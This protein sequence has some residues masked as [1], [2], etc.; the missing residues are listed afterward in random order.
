[1]THAILMQWIEFLEKHPEDILFSKEEEYMV[2]T[3]APKNFILKV[4]PHNCMI[5]T[6]GVFIILPV[7][8]EQLAEVNRRMTLLLTQQMVRALRAEI[9]FQPPESKKVF[10]FQFSLNRLLRG[11]QYL[12][13]V[14]LLAGIGW[15]LSG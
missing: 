12:L 3:Y 8:H 5:S 10:E 11:I 13:I 6:C 14:L 15:L 7:F 4:G 1:M 2:Y 9:D